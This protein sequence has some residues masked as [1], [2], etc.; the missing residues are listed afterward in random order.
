MW[1]ATTGRAGRA[2]LELDWFAMKMF[3]ARLRKTSPNNPII[4]WR[5]KPM[6]T[7]NRLFFRFTFSV[8]KIP[9]E[10]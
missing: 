10:C 8:R 3:L 4:N 5:G 7:K 1:A 2:G 6:Q 9:R